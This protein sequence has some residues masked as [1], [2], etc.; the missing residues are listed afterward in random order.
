MP[1]LAQ[2]LRLRGNPFEHYVA[3]LEPDISDYAVKPPY[4][5]A[6]EA[7]AQGCA[8]FILFG[9]RGAGKSATR[10]TIYKELWRKKSE[11]I[12][13]PFAINFTDFSA[14]L[15]GR[16]ITNATEASLV[17][18]TA[19]LV[20]EGLLTWLSS[21]EDDERLVYLGALDEGEKKL[22]YDLL[23]DYYLNRPAAKRQRSVREAMELFHQAFPAR[24]QLWVE[25][26]WESIAALIGNITDA[27]ARRILDT[28]DSVSSDV[29]S[30]LNKNDSDEFDSV[31]LLRRLADLVG[32]FHFSGVVIL[33]DKVD[34]TD[35][36]NNSADRTAELI[37]PLLA[38][39]QLMEVRNFSWIFFLWH[40]IRGLFEQE[41]HL[42][43]LDKIGHA[44]VSWEGRFFEIMLDRRVR[45]F[46]EQRL[47]LGGL[48]APD[49]DVSVVMRDLVRVSMR[50]P[51]ELIRLM[52]VIIRE[53]D[54]LHTGENDI[55]LVMS[56]S[57][58]AGIDV[59]VTDR[60]SSIFGERL[61][62]QI[63]RLNKTTFT[64]RDVQNTFRVGAQSARTRIQTWEQAGIIKLSGT[65]AAEGAQGGKP[66]NEYSIVDARVERV[67]QRQLVTY[68]DPLPIEIEPEVGGLE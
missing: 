59:Y 10:L 45:F 39:V 64:N 4:F 42:V 63:F 55:A 38:R 17:R 47:G 53:H 35:A 14:M 23:R 58:E 48:F 7:R 68:N 27:L 8:S 29:A 40:K 36:T 30:V 16:Q 44:S 26:R 51:R 31:L 2:A 34:E 13:V 6:I 21:L 1:T 9:D 49:V 41:V 62:A 67:M 46:S 56:A 25:R 19:F 52:D 11:G 66:A 65:R 22:C 33:V 43:R 28:R 5:E 20:I 60:V 24:S 15:S 37:H 12:R 61:L 50:S 57:I 18:E 54:V 3:E 32:I